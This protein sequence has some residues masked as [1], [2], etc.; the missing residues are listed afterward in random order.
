MA[1]KNYEN[2]KKK[3]LRDVS[4]LTKDLKKTV[5]ELNILKTKTLKYAQN[6]RKITSKSYGLGNSTY[7]ELLQSELKLQK[8]LMQKVMLE[9]KRDIKKVTLKY[10]KGESLNE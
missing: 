1:L 6:S 3:K 8:I 7:V 10:V 4:V 2:Y 5:S 9:A